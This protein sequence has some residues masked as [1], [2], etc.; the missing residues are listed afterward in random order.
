MAIFRK[1][2]TSFWGDPY[3]SGLTPE[4]KYFYLYLLTNER[5]RQCG[6]YEISKRQI[7][8]DTGYNIDTV[9]KILDFF[10]LGE[11]V[12]FNPDTNE[13]AIK[14]WGKYNSSES[15]QVKACINQELTKI[16]DKVLIE[17]VYS[18]HT[19]V[20]PPHNKN[21]NKNKNKKKGTATTTPIFNE[22]KA[23]FL[24]NGFSERLAKKAFDYYED[25]GWVDKNGKQVLNWKQKMQSVWFTE[26][27]DSSDQPEKFSD[28]WK[29]NPNNWL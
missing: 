3:I 29:K 24:E 27:Q 12:R 1:I 15:P 16:K 22:V 17:Y 13:I 9:S 18:I 2:H 19:V 28:E 21:K 7:C 4:Q 8:Y 6:I 14:N 11:K 10:I 26:D 20:I 25:S 23:Y 5:T